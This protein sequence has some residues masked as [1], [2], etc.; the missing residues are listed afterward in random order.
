MLRHF[1]LPHTILPA[2]GKRSRYLNENSHRKLVLFLEWI[3]M[4]FFLVVVA[5]LDIAMTCKSAIPSIGY[6]KGKQDDCAP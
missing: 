6:A 2:S 5:Q 4:W 3:S 1:R